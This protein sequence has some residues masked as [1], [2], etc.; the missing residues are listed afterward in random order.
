M[1]IGHSV[2]IG[3]TQTLFG[4]GGVSRPKIEVP[5]PVVAHFSGQQPPQ[6]PPK[7]IEPL[8]EIKSPTP[9]AESKGDVRK[10]PGEPSKIVEHA[11]SDERV[12]D[13]SSVISAKSS[14]GFVALVKKGLELIF[15][16]PLPSGQYQKF[17]Y[18]KPTSENYSGYA[19]IGDLHK[20]AE[21][22]GLSQKSDT[23]IS[24]PTRF[25]SSAGRQPS[26]GS[27]GL[28][29]TGVPQKFTIGSMLKRNDDSVG[30]RLSRPPALGGETPP[31]QNNEQNILGERIGSPLQ[32]FGISKSVGA[33]LRVCPGEHT[34]SPLQNNGVVV[35]DGDNDR[36]TGWDKIIGTRIVNDERNVAF[37]NNDAVAVCDR[38]GTGSIG[39]NVT[40]DQYEKNY[41]I[42]GG[43]RVY[44]ESA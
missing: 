40:E 42:P 9:K 31:L 35:F 37:G 33:D 43:V 18:P 30:T 13:F 20:T 4:P 38:N 3:F 26:K 11:S 39:V 34:G 23:R 19:M 15:S 12:G 16:S 14:T 5:A 27:S 10:N 24:P 2:I 41:I 8:A 6:A 7:K 1:I 36:P 29:A 32:N 25:I 28:I 44:S 17:E 21:R 22:L